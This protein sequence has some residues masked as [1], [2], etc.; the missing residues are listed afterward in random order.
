MTIDLFEIPILHIAKSLFLSLSYIT[1]YTTI[2]Y[3]RRKT[4]KGYLLRI[5]YVN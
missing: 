2:A 5:L 4:L 3:H 1:A